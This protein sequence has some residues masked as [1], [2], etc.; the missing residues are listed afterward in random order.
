MFLCLLWSNGSST[1]R[2][3]HVIGLQILVISFE[4]S[5]WRWNCRKCFVRMQFIKCS[6]LQF[7]FWRICT[8][9][10]SILFLLFFVHFSCG[11]PVFLRPSGFVN[12]RQVLSAVSNALLTLEFYLNF[13]FQ[14]LTAIILIIYKYVYHSICL[15]QV[16]D[17][18]INLKKRKKK[19]KFLIHCKLIECWPESLGSIRDA[20]VLYVFGSI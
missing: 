10:D 17:A 4:L 13:N 5:R 16:T 1:V 8:M 14:K 7:L 18:M 20:A 6:L 19:K 9:V 2:F 3:L 12:H 15:T 11:I